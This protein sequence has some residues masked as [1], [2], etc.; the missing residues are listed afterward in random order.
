MEENHRVR[1]RRF[2]QNQSRSHTAGG[3]LMTWWPSCYS[4]QFPIRRINTAYTMHIHCLF[5][6]DSL[7]IHHYSLPTCTAYTLPISC[8]FTEHHNITT[9]SHHHSITASSHHHR[10]EKSL[11]IILEKEKIYSISIILIL[12]IVENDQWIAARIAP[13]SSVYAVHITA[14][15]ASSQH[16]HAQHHHSI[17]TA[18]SQHHHSIITA[19]SQHNRIIITAW[20]QHHHIIIT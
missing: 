17:I 19:S 16:H 18:S 5:T 13:N 1:E 12:S 11:L 20:S 8:L 4:L 14:I 10:P 3:A 9:S 15:T 6:A 2:L 7:P